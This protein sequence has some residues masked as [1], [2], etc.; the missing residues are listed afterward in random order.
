MNLK[1][2]LALLL[3]LLL[4]LSLTACNEAVT[5]D[6]DTD[7]S[8]DTQRNGNDTDTNETNDTEETKTIETK[9]HKL[10]DIIDNIKTLGRTTTVNNGLACDH[11]ASGIEFNAY[12][13]G[14]LTLNVTVSK[15][16]ADALNDDCYFTL[17]IDG[18]RQ[19]QRLKAAKSTTT[20]LTIATFEKGGVHNIRLV[21][22]TEPRN[23]ISVLNDLSFTGYFEEAPA[24]SEYLIEFLGDSLTV[25]YG[26]LTSGGTAA[27]AQTAVNQD[28]TQAY[29]Y[30]TA[31]KLGADHSIIAASGIGLVRGYRSFP[32][33]QM[34]EKDSYY[35]NDATLFTPTR[36]PDLVVINLGSNDK[37]KNVSLAE[38]EK[39]A[40]DL[41]TQVGL[42]YG[43]SLPIILI[44]KSSYA[45][46]IQ[47]LINSFGDGL[48]MCQL[49]ENKD[50][51]NSHPS[52]EAHRLNAEE[53]TKFIQDN[54]ILK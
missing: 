34:F 14:T 3:S 29:A 31:E 2:I 46:V 19:E 16:I 47:G 43:K 6:S 18:T 51:G 21:K 44:Y 10:A 52:A 8:A 7:I 30:L 5:N 45:S 33:S 11:V 12:I 17:Y 32:M 22:Q 35:R 26:N 9:T 28:V 15:G 41:I 42:T 37:S 27:V 50:G 39:G 53:L 1:R 23:S 48:Y 36:T 20:K 38:Y 4:C 25:G 24:D 13:E 40:I 54:N 49:T